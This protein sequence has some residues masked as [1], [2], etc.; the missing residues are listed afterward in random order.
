MEPRD[1]LKKL[2]P[3]QFSD[4]KIIDK[5][6]CPKTLLDFHLSNLS[7]KNKHFNFEEFVKKINIKQA[8]EIGKFDLESAVILKD[9]EP[10][11]PPDIENPPIK[12]LLNI[13]KTR[14]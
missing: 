3:N 11:I 12:E 10:I 13:L 2:H 5:I 6:E 8:Y 4:S 1:I 7:E 9:D 14:K